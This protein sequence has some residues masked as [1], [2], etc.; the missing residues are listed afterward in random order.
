M[1]TLAAL[2]QLS[3]RSSIN[4]LEYLAG[5]MRVLNVADEKPSRGHSSGSWLIAPEGD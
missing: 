2:A 4:I 1:S 3:I 5:E